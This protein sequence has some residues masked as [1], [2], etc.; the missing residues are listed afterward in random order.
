MCTTALCSHMVLGSL[1]SA[2]RR[3][4]AVTTEIAAVQTLPS[5]RILRDMCVELTQGHGQHEARLLLQLTA[6]LHFFRSPTT[7]NAIVTTLVPHQYSLVQM[8][9][10]TIVLQG[11]LALGRITSSP[12]GLGSEHSLV[13][14]WVILKGSLPKIPQG[15][16]GP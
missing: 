4:N 11:C 7:Q 15:S 16:W 8:P 13:E 10:T 5:W 14:I 2:E 3:K 9:K 6:S 1:A 12:A